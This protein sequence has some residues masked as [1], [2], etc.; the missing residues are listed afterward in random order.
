MVKSECCCQ[1]SNHLT[2]NKSILLGQSQPCKGDSGTKLEASRPQLKKFKGSTWNEPS[3]PF[4]QMYFLSWQ[5]S[6]KGYF[7][8]FSGSSLI[9]WFDYL[10][11]AC[12]K[13]Y[14]DPLADF[15]FLSLCSFKIS[16]IITMHHSSNH[17]NHY[18]IRVWY[19]AYFGNFTLAVTDE[20]RF[21]I[22]TIDLIF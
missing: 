14:A 2:N 20:A 6:S 8:M 10:S 19:L 4:F 3:Y 13:L 21:Q 12:P 15:L 7:I 17:R 1:C 16:L 11:L 22:G 5:N 18:P 9:I